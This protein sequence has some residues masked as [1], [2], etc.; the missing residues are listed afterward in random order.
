MKF[1]N[2]FLIILV[3][4]F[5]LFLI[6]NPRSFADYEFDVGGTT[7]SVP[8]FDNLVEN[9]N[10]I[11]SYTLSDSSDIYSVN[12]LVLYI[13]NDDSIFELIDNS[14]GSYS[15]GSSNGLTYYNCDYYATYGSHN[16][17]WTY[18]NSGNWS[19]YSGTYEKAV[20]FMDY[21][22]LS[23]NS[24]IYD[25]VGQVVFREAG[26]TG[27]SGNSGDSGNSTNNSTNSGSGQS[28]STNSTNTVSGSDSSS[29]GT[30]DN[31]KN[32]LVN[33][34]ENVFVGFFEGI[35][36]PLKTIGNGISNIFSTIGDV[37]SGVINLKNFL[38]PTS[39][40]FIFKTFFSYF[41]PFSDNFI[42]KIAFIPSEDY[43]ND[44][45]TDCSNRLDNK[46]HFRQHYE[47]LEAINDEVSEGGQT[48]IDTFVELPEYK[49]V[50]G[51][52]VSMPKFIDFSFVGQYRDTWFA[53]CRVVFYIMI[54]IYNI[55]QIIKF[56]NGHTVVEGS[57][58]IDGVSSAGQHTEGVGKH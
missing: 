56:L 7:Y 28:D 40:T 30:N 34:L 44:Q 23:S 4:F 54:V 1:K 6:A 13:L 18:V 25:S 47:A 32:W 29:F 24:N 27:G 37:L 51:L 12:Y 49:I 38:D 26:T 43:F 16:F 2:K 39:D 58:K 46:I 45:Y 53:W 42:L 35:T 15:I 48:N 19:L 8:D 31:S 17:S 55:S 22:I 57:N 36:N 11:L 9:K 20:R 21:Q 5:S 3:L 33:I 10:Y 41:N 14:N 50:D 52:S